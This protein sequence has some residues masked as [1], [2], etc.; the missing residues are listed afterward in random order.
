MVWYAALTPPDGFL[1]CN[2]QSTAGYPTLASIVGSTVPDL[3]GRFIRGWSHN[4][5]IDGGRIFGSLQEDQFQGHGHRMYYY[6]K[7]RQSETSGNWYFNN[8]AGFNLYDD[9][10]IGV[11]TSDGINGIARV[12]SETRP[13]NVALLPC[14][15]ALP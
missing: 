9:T 8:G 13:H 1:E 5:I 2:G 15:R 11:I 7:S 4:G 6:A 14:I 3:R 10:Q 12:G